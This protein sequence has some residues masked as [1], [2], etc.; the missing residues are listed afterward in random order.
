V[1]HKFIDPSVQHLF[2]NLRNARNTATHAKKG[3]VTPAEA[4]DYQKQA[5]TLKALFQ[6]VLDHLPP[7]PNPPA[8]Q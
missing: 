4:L 5:R 1:S 8:N 6:R 3:S 2:D 7:N